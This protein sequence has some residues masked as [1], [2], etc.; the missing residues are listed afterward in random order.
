MF[1]T[2]ALLALDRYEQSIPEADRPQQVAARLAFWWRKL[3]LDEAQL[4]PRVPE[5]TPGGS[6]AEQIL[7]MAGELAIDPDNKWGLIVAEATSQA[8][9]LA[10]IEHR[11]VPLRGI[12]ELRKE[13]QEAY[14]GGLTLPSDPN[15]WLGQS[16]ARL[17]RAA[18][19]RDVV[20]LGAQVRVSK[21]T[22]EAADALVAEGQRLID[23]RNK[24]ASKK[25]ERPP[26]KQ[27]WGM[28]LGALTSAY[29][30]YAT[31][32]SGMHL[33]LLAH[34]ALSAPAVYVYLQGSTQALGDL[35]SNK[36]AQR[37]Y[38]HRLEPA[39]AELRS[40]RNDLVGQLRDGASLPARD[41]RAIDGKRDRD[42]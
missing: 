28:R 7:E 34:A 12:A 38:E 26:A 13:F 21:P 14:N 31:G 2:E 39:Q 5:L 24:L 36:E 20:A 8:Q 42:R 33:P 30:A 35:E 37:A 32:L 9:A 4:D 16:L 41:T 40:V 27:P 17:G 11:D 18:V 10:A 1:A 25:A 23:E 3:R 22:R 15:D 29:F 6:D 19:L